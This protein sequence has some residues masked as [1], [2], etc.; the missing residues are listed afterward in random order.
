M[1]FG[2]KKAH[3]LPLKNAPPLST[4][5]VTPNSFSG[6]TDN[7]FNKTLKVTFASFF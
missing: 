3:S 5:F 1:E 6:E 7:Y 2:Q 4:L